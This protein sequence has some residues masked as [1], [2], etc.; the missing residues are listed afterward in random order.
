MKKETKKSLLSI[1]VI[2]LTFIVSVIIILF[3][4]M[5]VSISKYKYANYYT[6]DKEDKIPSINYILGKRKLYY[7]K[8]YTKNNTPYKVL[9]YKNIKNTKSDLSTYINT[10]RDDYNFVLTSDM[11]LSKD[12]GS[13]QLCSNSVYKN[14]IIILNI[15]YNK[16]KYSI[17][18]SVNNGYINMLKK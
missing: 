15:N 7:Y 17:T 4:S 9:K 6:I 12:N 5:I 13:I 10:L 18:I 8:S 3:V 1:L 2:T 16:N 11:N 14:K